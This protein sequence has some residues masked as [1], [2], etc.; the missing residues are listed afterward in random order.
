M[1]TLKNYVEHKDVFIYQRNINVIGIAKQINV[2]G[3]YGDKSEQVCRTYQKI[4]NLKVDG[5]CGNNTWTALINDVKRIQ[6][7]INDEGYTPKLVIDGIVGEKTNK[8]IVWVTNKKNS[9]ANAINNEK[10]NK[11]KKATIVLDPGHGT[12]YNKYKGVDMTEGENMQLMA[13]EIK[14]LLEKLGYK[15]VITRTEDKDMS[16]T[17]RTRVATDN[18]ADA[19][20]SLHTNA[21][22]GSGV[23]VYYSVDLK[24]NEAKAKVISAEI[25][26][27]LGIVNRGAKVRE[28]EKY[29]GEDYFSII[30]MPQDAGIKNVFLVEFAFHDNINEAKMLVENRKD[31]A[32]AFVN[33]VA[34]FM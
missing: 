15:V 28:S 22:G 9:E 23:E 6:K 7:K 14:P 25:S 10:P 17:N 20:F 16:F 19:I 4:R 29:K 1:Q 2:D 8:G 33:A 24:D 5:I 13:K 18:K 11:P 21:G 34:K 30:D 26:K 31:F 12:G 3:K 32:Q 27:S